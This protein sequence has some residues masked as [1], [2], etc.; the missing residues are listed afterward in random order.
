MQ[1]IQCEPTFCQNATKQ[2]E[3]TINNLI[4][5]KNTKQYYYDNDYND[6]DDYDD[7]D[8]DDDDKMI[9][10]KMTM[11]MMTVM[12]YI[13]IAM[14]MKMTAMMTMIMI[15]IQETDD[16]ILPEWLL[17]WHQDEHSPL[18]TE[19]EVNSQGSV[20]DRKSSCPLLPFSPL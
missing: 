5:F 18:E 16:W 6:D 2:N 8:Y 20:A 4:L 1:L 13:I 9:M 19:G 10:I 12:I 3:L 11:I 7:L 17:E 14:T 15:K